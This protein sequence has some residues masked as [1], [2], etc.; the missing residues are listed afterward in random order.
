MVEL[1]D[2]DKRNIANMH[3]E[4]TRYAVFEDDDGWSNEQKFAWMDEGRDGSMRP[5]SDPT[6]KLAEALA[7][8][9]KVFP[10]HYWMLGK[11]KTRPD[12]PLF[13][14]ALFDKRDAEEPIACGEHDDPVEAVKRA[15]ADIKT[16][17]RA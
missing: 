13:G 3:P 10:N 5:I 4:A 7:T 17:G 15:V 1:T 16:K 12:E 14:F 6:A 11:G 9:E 8:A 2:G